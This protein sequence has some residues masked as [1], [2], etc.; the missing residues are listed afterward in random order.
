MR[1]G[2]TWRDMVR[3]GAAAFRKTSGTLMGLDNDALINERLGMA[4]SPGT[5]RET[6]QTR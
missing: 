3:L 4:R 1:H 6:L 5:V 2:A